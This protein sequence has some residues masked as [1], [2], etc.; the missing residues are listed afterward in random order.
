MATEVFP[1]AYGAPPVTGVI[2]AEPEDF[3][4]EEMLGFT[5]LGQGEHAFLRVQKRG[6][7]TDYLARQLAKF[8]AVPRQSVSY[9]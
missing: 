3:I 2:K 7:N 6:E 5:P 1:Y 4:V 9:A 8:A